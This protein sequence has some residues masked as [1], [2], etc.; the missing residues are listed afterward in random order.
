MVD[1]HSLAGIVGLVVAA[2][3]FCIHSNKHIAHAYNISTYLIGQVQSYHVRGL[4][5]NARFTCFAV[6]L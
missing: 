6:V 1:L 3:L 2:V 5:N 4:D